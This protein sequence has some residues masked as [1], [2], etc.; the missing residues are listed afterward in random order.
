MFFSSDNL[1]NNGCSIRQ[2]AH[3]DAQ[4]LINVKLFFLK[5]F[6]VKKFSLSRYE[7]LKSGISLLI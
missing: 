4:K 2:G 7:T 6:F 3:H 5:S 1:I